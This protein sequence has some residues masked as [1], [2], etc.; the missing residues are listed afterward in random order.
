MLLAFDHQG[1]EFGEPVLG[2][3]SSGMTMISHNNGSQLR[4]LLFSLASGVRIPAGEGT[5]VT[6]PI[7][8]GD[9]GLSLAEVQAADYQGNTLIVESAKVAL[10]TAFELLQN[11]PNPFNAATVIR[12]ALPVASDWQL[13]IYN[14]T[15]QLVDE[16][17]GH[18]AAGFI[19]VRWDAVDRAS[20]VYFYELIAGDFADTRKMVLTK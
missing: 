9:H 7:I 3:N 16:F 14:V 18:A 13:R 2:E 10:P 20:G 8:A 6:I 4:I 1:M 17:T 11:Y 5:I 19:T 15:G 12:F